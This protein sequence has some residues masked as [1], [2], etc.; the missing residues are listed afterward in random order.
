MNC[1]DI[2]EPA[3]MA[4]KKK[5]RFLPKTFLFSPHTS[6]L[7]HKR[8]FSHFTEGKKISL[9]LSHNS[10]TYTCGPSNLPLDGPFKGGVH[11]A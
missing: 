4:K 8:K 6:A 10:P 3:P 2:P 5:K 11:L 9:L 1:S 7:V